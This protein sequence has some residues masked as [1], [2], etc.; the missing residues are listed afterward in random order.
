MELFS[1]RRGEDPAWLGLR[2]RILERGDAQSGP[3]G[4]S[5]MEELVST[6]REQLQRR[7]DRCSAGE[8]A[9]GHYPA[10]TKFTSRL[11]MTT[12]FFSVFP[13]SHAFT[14]GSAAAAARISSSVAA[15]ETCTSPR[16]LP[17]TC[18][19]IV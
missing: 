11:G 14:L 5:A 17:F 19:A 2:R 9:H 1:R 6:G 18:T 15:A 3:R 12:H 8:A 7:Q 16:S 13:S 4:I 10:T